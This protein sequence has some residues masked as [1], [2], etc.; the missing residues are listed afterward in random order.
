M[1]GIILLLTTDVIYKKVGDLEAVGSLMFSLFAVIV[2][3][4]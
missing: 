3:S 1:M 4:F 2:A